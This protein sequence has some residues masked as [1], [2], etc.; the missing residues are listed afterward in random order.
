MAI[1]DWKK[2]EENKKNFTFTN[3]KTDEYIDV[4][5]SGSTW[6]IDFPDDTTKRVSN[7]SKA[8]AFAA[9]YMRKH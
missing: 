5:E 2:T 7:K 3:K 1:K 9:V 8:F 4:Y 6:R